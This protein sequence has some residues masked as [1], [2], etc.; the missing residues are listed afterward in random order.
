MSIII[1]N[2]PHDRQV[3]DEFA[4]LVVAQ[5]LYLQSEDNKKPIQMYIN[6]PGVVVFVPGFIFVKANI[7]ICT[8]T[9]RLI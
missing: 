4:S 9:Y 1:Y 3:T 6:S 5:L 2:T 7:N 8:F